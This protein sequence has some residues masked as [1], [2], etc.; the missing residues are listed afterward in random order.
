MT[1]RAV[2]LGAVL[3]AALAAAG[4]ARAGRASVDPVEIREAIEL[5]WNEARLPGTT[6][7]IRS[8]PVLRHA[9]GLA[10]VE[11]L[12]P[13]QPLRPGP[14]AVPVSA[15]VEGRV[16][17]RGLAN[18]VLRR[19]MTVWTPVRPLE[20]GSVVTR[21]DL[22][23]E[24]RVYDRDPYRLFEDPGDHEWIVVRSVEAGQVLRPNDLRRRPDVEAGEEITLVSRAGDASVT[25]V[26]RARRSGSVGDTILVLNP[27]TGSIVSAVL[28]AD[29][30]ARIES[31]ARPGEGGSS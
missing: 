23:A 1:T 19:K 13:D 30:T 3:L 20:P 26:G 9:G 21:A 25:V 2:R 6:L 17:S 12:L 24:P 28:Q 27:V 11:V 10:I 7:E 29:G 31:P 4:P 22:R 16:V 18:V 15:R 8:L 14:R 5:A